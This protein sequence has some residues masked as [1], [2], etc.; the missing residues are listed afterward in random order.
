MK[1]ANATLPRWDGEQWVYRPYINGVQKKY[2]STKPEKAGYN[3]CLRKHNIA[4][5]GNNRQVRFDNAWQ[6][7][8][9]DRLA[10]LG[11]TESYIKSES[12]GRCHLLPRLKSK[13][14]STITDQDWQNCITLAKS[15]SGKPL[16]KKSL[17]NIRAEIMLFC[18]FAK[19]NR[20]IDAM[21]D[22]L[23]VP[24][25]AFKVGK[26]IL[27]PKELRT[28]LADSDGD[29]Y[30]NAWRLMVVTGLR[31]GEAYGLKWDDIDDVISVRR[32]INRRGIITGG[33]N[34]NAIRTLYQTALSRAI[35]SDQQV[36]TSTLRSEWVFCDPDG[37]KPVPSTIA[38]HWNE[39]RV[40]FP[41]VTQY[42]LRHTFVSV[43]KSALPDALMKQ[44]VGH[45]QSMDTLGVYGKEIASD[46]KQAAKIIDGVFKKYKTSTQTSIRKIEKA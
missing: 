15:T 22:D 31:P 29:W 33:K 14:V 42:G 3:E 32:S 19:K 30:I 21:P 26:E 41:N 25:N 12:I 10:S 24:K 13:R 40:D 16:S 44:T 1:R 34:E 43:S 39:Y 7:H 4:L 2:I 20:W 9:A 18:K 46:K 45:S 27:H 23:Q 38:N 11:K 5:S 17:T 6:D 28:L 37:C 8:L 35:L 36:Q